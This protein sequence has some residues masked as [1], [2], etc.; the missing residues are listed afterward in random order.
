M[1]CQKLLKLC[2]SKKKKNLKSV[3]HMPA[4]S[5]FVMLENNFKRKGLSKNFLLI[6]YFVFL[7]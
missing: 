4:Y 1:L 3:F 6:L 2:S 5:N 7:S